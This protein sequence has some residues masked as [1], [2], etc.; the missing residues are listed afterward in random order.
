MQILPNFYN[1]LTFKTKNYEKIKKI[2]KNLLQFIGRQRI[3][4]PY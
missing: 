3:I 1:F 2:F 4:Y